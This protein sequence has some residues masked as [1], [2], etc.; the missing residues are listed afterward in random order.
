MIITIV[1]TSKPLLAVQ[2]TPIARA[3]SK[4]INLRESCSRVI[5]TRPVRKCSPMTSCWVLMA[6]EVSFEVRWASPTL[7]CR[8][9]DSLPNPSVCPTSTKQL[10]SWLLNR[11]ATGKMAVLHSSVTNLATLW[12]GIIQ[13][14]S[15]QTLLLSLSAFTTATATCKCFCDST[16]AM[17]YGTVSSRMSRGLSSFRG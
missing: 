7:G 12:M 9:F 4:A 13:R 1:E 6:L 15:H 11:L 8:S 3:A 5:P 2:R 17:H 14:S 10:S 16:W